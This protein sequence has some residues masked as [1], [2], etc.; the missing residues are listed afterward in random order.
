MFPYPSLLPLKER[1]LEEKRSAVLRACRARM[2]GERGE[3]DEREMR[4]RGGEAREIERACKSAEEMCATPV[5]CAALRCS[6]F[7]MR[8]H[9]LNCCAGMCGVSYNCSVRLM[10]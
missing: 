2:D 3:R 7:G 9:N 5:P 4:E 10:Y 8:G 6:S 1:Q